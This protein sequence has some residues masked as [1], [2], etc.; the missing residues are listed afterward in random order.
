VNQVERFVTLGVGH[1]FSPGA[2]LKVLYQ[3]TEVTGAG[4]DA[5]APVLRGG[6]A[7]AQIQF[8]Y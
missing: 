2:N 4:L 1:T 5:A 7:A 3:I 8:R 6:V